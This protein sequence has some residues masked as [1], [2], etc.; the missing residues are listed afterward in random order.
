[1]LDMIKSSMRGGISIIT[2]RYSKANNKYMDKLYDNNKEDIYNI[3]LDA[4]NLYGWAMSQYLPISAYKWNDKITLDK[5]LNT[6]DDNEIGY[7]VE[8]DIHIPEELHDYFNCYP[9]AVENTSYEASPYMNEIKEKLNI[10]D[11]KV[12]KLIPNLYD[13]IKYV[14][15]YRNLKLYKSLGLK[16]TKIHRVLEFK[17]TPYLQDYIMFNTN[18]RT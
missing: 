13:K 7:I 16:I 12:N 8:C 14:L 18:M 17:Q 6:K 3:Y 9:L 11:C 15:H 1:M 10:K 5:I 4:N 2:H